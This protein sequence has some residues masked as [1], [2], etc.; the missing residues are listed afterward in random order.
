M[1]CT[2]YCVSPKQLVVTVIFAVIV[3]AIYYQLK[4]DENGIQN[5]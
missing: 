5:R 2:N 3:G 1:I 4:K